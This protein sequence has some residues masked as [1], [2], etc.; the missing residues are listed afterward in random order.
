MIRV[1]VTEAGS[2]FTRSSARVLL[3]RRLK[4]GWPACPRGLFRATPF[5]RVTLRP[6]PKA[7]T[8]ATLELVG[9][10]PRGNFFS[11]EA[12]CRV[13]HKTTDHQIP[14]FLSPL[15]RDRARPPVPPAARAIFVLYELPKTVLPAGLETAP[16]FPPREA[17]GSFRPPRQRMRVRS[18]RSS[19]RP[20]GD[21]RP[22]LFP[23]PISP[24]FLSPTSTNSLLFFRTQGRLSSTGV[25]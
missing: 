7:R 14:L 5:P 19:G 23:P 15:F 22:P 11:M 17:G 6:S 3:R 13:T 9:L 1:S 8:S 24:F 18:R 10:F 16:L 12:R 2:F 21:R 20:F 25:S 4:G